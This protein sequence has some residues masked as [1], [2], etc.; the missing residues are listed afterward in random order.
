M[1][2]NLIIFGLAVLLV[3]VGLSGCFDNDNEISFS[4]L[5]DHFSKYVGKTVTIRGYVGQTEK[6]QYPVDDYTSWAFFYESN[7]FE[8][9]QAGMEY[10]M[11]L[12]PTNITVYRGWYKIMGLVEESGGIITIFANIKVTSAEAV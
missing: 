10:I 9:P 5:R 7:P 12:L 8:N 4:E 1:N 6:Y 3:C 2:K 11:L